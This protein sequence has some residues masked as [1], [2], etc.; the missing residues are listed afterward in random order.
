MDA[1]QPLVSIVTPFYNSEAFLAECIRSVV[2]QTYENFEYI[3]LDNCSTDGS[4]AIAR[5]F[6]ARDS[7]IKVHR[8][9]QLIPQVPNYNTALRLISASSRYVKI[10]QADDWLFPECVERMV[11]LA[12][13]HPRIGIVSSYSLWG[14]N[15]DGVGLPHGLDVMSGRDICR[16]QLI[17]GG[18]WF[19]SPTVVM[20]RA[21]IVRSRDPFFSEGRLHEDTEACYE[22]LRSEDFGFVH[23][24]LSYMRFDNESISQ[25]VRDFNPNALD[26][27]IVVV[28]YGP[29]FLTADEQER[30][31]QRAER[32]YYRYLGRSALRFRG[33]KFW[34]YHR[35]GLK[36][37]GRGLPWLRLVPGA[38]LDL[39]DMA[40]NP[41][42]TLENAIATLRGPST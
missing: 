9:P 32:N 29:D 28:R 37:I 19:G 26:R 1:A 10:V 5:E 38:V 3:L 35:E 33:S 24:L 27:L 39:V 12:V 18:F 25:R 7:R 2:G 14:V 23:Q 17:H 22:I 4:T 21:D 42:R 20:Y 40:L 31:L 6:A 36:T 30:V 8:N 15:I 34:A 11:A 13:A 16:R 41:K